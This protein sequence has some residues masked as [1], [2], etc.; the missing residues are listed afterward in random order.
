MSPINEIDSHCEEKM[1]KITKLIAT[2]IVL[3]VTSGVA[4]A[5]DPKESGD[6]L[7]RDLS[8]T[9]LGWAGHVGIWTGS[10]V[11]E[12]LNV[13]DGKA[14]QQNSLS[15][16][17][18]ASNYWGAKY[19]KAGSKG[20][21]IVSAGW[22][23]RN[24]YPCYTTTSHYQEGGWVKHKVWDAVKKKYVEKTVM[25]TAK[26][27]CDTFVYYSYDKGAGMKLTGQAILPKI[28]YNSLPKTR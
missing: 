22:E 28:V 23:Q 7:G 27:R 24:Y 9:G 1:K 15:S 17:K 2:A 10:K 16:F 11:L 6:V 8:I 20:S 21:K 18:K 3:S 14:V 25:Q 26:F 13:E 4:F 19:G 12:V 5:G